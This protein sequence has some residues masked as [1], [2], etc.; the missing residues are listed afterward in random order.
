MDE[1]SLICLVLVMIGLWT[2]L[3]GIRF[4]VVWLQLMRMCFAS[5]DI[6]RADRS[7]M[8]AE[9]A[10]ILDPMFDRLAALGFAYE[11]TFLAQPM[12]RYA[13]AQPVWIDVH[14]HAPSGSR[15]SV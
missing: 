12:L 11:E 7:A 13:D 1:K 8:P 5:G 9:V 3:I 2:G 15:A 14:A 10:A 4:L 6:L